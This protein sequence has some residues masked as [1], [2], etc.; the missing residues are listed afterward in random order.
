MGDSAQPPRSSTLEH[1]FASKLFLECGVVLRPAYSHS[2]GA[3][4]PLPSDFFLHSLLVPAT[5][6]QQVS[7]HQHAG[8]GCLPNDI[9]RPRLLVSH[10]I[11]NTTCSKASTERIG[12][13][14]DVDRAQRGA[15]TRA[16]GTQQPRRAAASRRAF[17]LPS[18]LDP[19]MSIF[20][21]RVLVCLKWS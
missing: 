4:T 10:L 7:L 8:M 9:A 12:R 5:R 20:E 6:P 3:A 17:Q 16:Q 11:S 19:L 15:C 21:E 13:G 14:G 1:S 2:L 18:L